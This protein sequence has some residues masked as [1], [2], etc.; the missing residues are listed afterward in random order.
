MKFKNVIL[1]LGLSGLS[2]YDKLLNKD[3]SLS[4]EQNVELGGYSRTINIANYRFDY[5]G[6]FLHL[7][8]IR[9]L[10]YKNL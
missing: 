7:K 1:G 4:I 9:L 10:C 5:T 6:H 3:D 8:Y 2:F